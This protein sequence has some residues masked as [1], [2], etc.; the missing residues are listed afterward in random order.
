L[1]SGRVS[2]FKAVKNDGD[3]K[4]FNGHLDAATIDLHA[5]HNYTGYV[6]IFL[7]ISMIFKLIVNILCF[8]RV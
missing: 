6:Q 5:I 7:S 3:I 4:M 2:S 8:G 1:P